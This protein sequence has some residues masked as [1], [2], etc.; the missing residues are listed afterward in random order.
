MD[1]KYWSSSEYNTLEKLAENGN[2]VEVTAAIHKAC[3]RYTYKELEKR[4]RENDIPFEKIQTVK[5]VLVDEEAFANDQLRRVKYD[6]GQGY[7]EDN[8]YTVTTTPFRLKSIGD[9]ILKRSRP[10]GYDTR[11]VAKEYGYSDRDIDRMIN[12]GA[13]LEYH[14]APLPKGVLEPSY[15]PHS[16]N[17]R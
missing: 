6:D 4:F 10:I 1:E 9:P 5:D 13:V 3:M 11:E 2:Y 15:G 16:A 12:E 14:G 7:G 17:Y 8:S